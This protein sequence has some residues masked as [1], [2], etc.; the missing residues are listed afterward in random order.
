M[1]NLSL[2]D[3]AKYSEAVDRNVKPYVRIIYVL[4]SLLVCSLIGNIYLATKPLTVEIEQDYDSS[5]L[6]KTTGVENK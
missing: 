5:D 1:G 2:E 3:Y 6:N 4:C